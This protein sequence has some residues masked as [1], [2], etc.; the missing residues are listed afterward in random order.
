MV[1]ELRAEDGALT[2]E[3]GIL[4]VETDADVDA[5]AVG[6]GIVDVEP[7]RL[8][9]SEGWVRRGGRGSSDQVS[10]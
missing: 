6:M 7:L 1:R 9:S 5:D 10:I 8:P 4:D 2:G 3:V